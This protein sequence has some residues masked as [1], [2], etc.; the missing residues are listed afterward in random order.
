MSKIP[1]DT[2]LYESVKKKLY[3]KEPKHSAY[4]SMRLIDYYE[5]AF[6]DKY[7]YLDEKDAYIKTGKPSGLKRW[8]REKWTNQSGE[9]GYKSKSDVYRPSVRV[10]KDTPVTWSELTDKEIAS[11]RREKART[12]RVSRFKTDNKYSQMSTGGAVDNNTLNLSLAQVKKVKI[13]DFPYIKITEEDRDDAFEKLQT[14]ECGKDLTLSVMGNKASNY[15]F[16]PYRSKT[17]IG[18]WSHFSAWNDPVKRKRI[19]EIDKQINRKKPNIIGTPSG[20]ISA[21]RMSL[22]SVNQFKPYIAICAVYDR[23]KP[24]RVLDISAGW[25]D[26][27]VGAMARNI[28]Y[29]GIDQNKKLEKPYKQMIKDFKSSKHSG[30]KS[31]VKMIFK[32]SQDV[33]Y[34]KLPPY[35]L[36]FTSPPYF[37]LEQ[38]E[39]MEVFKDKEDFIE[40]YWKP[41]VIPAFKYLDKGGHMA[42]NMPEEMYKPL[43]KIIGKADSKIK[44]PIQNREAWKK[45]KVKKFEYIYVWNK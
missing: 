13:P 20:L 38:Y 12:G 29:T 4:R 19:I 7:P 14:L 6:T 39:G 3:K 42:L 27:L 36:I 34:S 32:K 26:R 15:Y 25:G 11:A 23:F 28:D 10:S 16:Q 1:V 22:G 37:D 43:I 8:I 18:K 40:N 45:D 41:T 2:K 31:E 30:G 33:D 17:K 9:T 5:D 21:M 35:D 24:K 44:M